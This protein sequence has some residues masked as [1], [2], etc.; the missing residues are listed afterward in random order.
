MEGQREIKEGVR[1]STVEREQQVREISQ[2][3]ERGGDLH[4]LPTEGP[5]SYVCSHYIMKFMLFT[6]VVY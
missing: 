1:Q 6:S 4:C 3:E 5:A 2:E